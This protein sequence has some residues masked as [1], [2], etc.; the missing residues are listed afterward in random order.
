MTIGSGRDRRR[1]EKVNPDVNTK[2]RLR[3]TPGGEVMEKNVALQKF[4]WAREVEVD[5]AEVM[6]S[7]VDNF[8]K[9]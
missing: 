9:F 1:G 3:G 4:G 7:E 5:G 6:G 8:P 2:S